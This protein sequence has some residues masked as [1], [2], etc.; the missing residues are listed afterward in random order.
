MEYT[1]YITNKNYSSWSLRPWLLMRQLGLPFK[2]VMRPL[3]PGSYRQPQWKEFSPVAHVPCLHITSP[4]S[5]PSPGSSPREPEEAI[6]LWE[7]LA[8]VDYLAEAFP[9]L[10][11][12]PP[13]AMGPAPTP[14]VPS[15]QSRARRAWAR[16]AVAEMHAGFSALRGEMGMCVGLRVQL[17]AQPSPGLLADLA[18]IDELWTEGLTRWGGPFLAGPQFG[19]V[20]AFYAPVALRLQTYVGSEK[21]L[22]EKARQYAEMIRGLEGVREWVADAVKE[23]L[24]EPV[25]EKEIVEGFGGVERLVLEDLRAAA[26]VTM[27]E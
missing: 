2:E 23:T 6:V 4:P 24:R 14:T 8:I 18:R 15:V 16:S 26:A 10:P 27:A 9:G 22:S 3:T 25:H 12:Y 7:S 1:L 21:Y 11:I 20:D 5:P 17:E 13:L 19:A